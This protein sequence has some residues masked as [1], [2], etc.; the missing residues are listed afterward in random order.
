MLGLDGVAGLRGIP[1]EP[2]D[3]MPEELVLSMLASA[4]G[5]KGARGLHYVFKQLLIRTQVSFYSYYSTN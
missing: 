5:P 4:A 3:S 2:G 1:G